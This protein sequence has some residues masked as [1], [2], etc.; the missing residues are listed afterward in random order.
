MK[1]NSQILEGLLSEKWS[2][3]KINALYNVFNTLNS[4]Y[5]YM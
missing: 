2:N 1:L 4:P 5:N 3:H